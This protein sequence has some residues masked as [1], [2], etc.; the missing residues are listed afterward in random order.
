MMDQL[1]QNDE[2]V[3]IEHNPESDRYII[4][5]SNGTFKSGGSPYGENTGSYFYEAT[6]KVLELDSD[7]GEEDD[8]KWKVDFEDG[9]KWQGI[10]SEWAEGF[11]ILYKKAE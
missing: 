2:D 11:I 5:F 1:I 7:A 8:S 4:F 9:M 10:G 3:T 6:S